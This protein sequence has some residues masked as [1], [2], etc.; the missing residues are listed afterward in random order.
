MFSAPGERGTVTGIWNAD[1]GN[2]SYV[3]AS[4]DES[5]SDL[6]IGGDGSSFYFLRTFP[7]RPGAMEIHSA[8]IDGSDNGAIWTSDSDTLGGARPAWSSGGILVPTDA[9]WLLVD[10]GGNETTLGANPYGSVGAPVLSPGEGLMAYSAGDQVV[11]AW[12]TDPGTAVA[13][14]PLGAGS[15]GYAFSTSGEEVVVS[16]GSA[17]HVVSYEGEDLGNLS[18]NQPIGGVYWINDTIYYLQVGGEAALKSTSLDAI[19]SG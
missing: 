3:P 16:D 4:E 7:D 11:V 13:T 12:T 15:G 8:T 14:A 6:P 5:S 17:L 9:E 1:S 19:Q 18:G 2:L 10:A